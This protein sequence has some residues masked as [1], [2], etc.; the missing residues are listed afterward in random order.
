MLAKASELMHN[1]NLQD[2]GRQNQTEVAKIFS[3]EGAVDAFEKQ[4]LRIVG[5]NG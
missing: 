3:R 5:A 4:L 1:P 2:I